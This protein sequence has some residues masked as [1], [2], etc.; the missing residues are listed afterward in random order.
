MTSRASALLVFVAA[1]SLGACGRSR[2]DF[3]VDEVT[4]AAGT[5]LA[6]TK[7]AAG[8][9][10]GTAGTRGAAGAGAAGTFGAA[11]T[12]AA[13]T[14]GAAGTAP[15][16]ECAP[17][18]TR[19]ASHEAVQTCT[20]EGKWS[21]AAP[22]EF[23]CPNEACAR[24]DK[25]VF[26]TSLPFQG[27]SLGGL[28]GA[29]ALCGKLAASANL[30]GFFR[31]WLSDA[32]ESPAIRFDRDGGPYRLVDG[33]IVA[34][35][36]TTLTTKPLR[37]AIDRTELGGPPPL[38]TGECDGPFVWSATR[39]DGTFHE[40]AYT[41][42]GWTDPQSRGI[43]MGRAD[44]VDVWSDACDVSSVGLSPDLCESLAALYCFEQ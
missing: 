31:A 26:V 21:S 22:C 17:R 40:N 8:T 42:G 10:A 39:E 3:S 29:D 5:G 41:C 30:P 18:A 37:H 32:M 14:F 23:V 24:N 1:L 35:K 28:D 43:S 25:I 44:S 11:G 33:T 12:A 19:C 15:A 7:G 13:G 16:P 4:G 20:P 36:W 9:G 34:N 27:G 38:A 2:L 6:G